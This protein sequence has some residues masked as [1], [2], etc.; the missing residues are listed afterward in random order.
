MYNEMR[1]FI[2]NV[3]LGIGTRSFQVIKPISVC[4]RHLQDTEIVIHW[5]I[6]DHQQGKHTKTIK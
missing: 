5:F 3:L 6:F 2:H 4:C 1:R